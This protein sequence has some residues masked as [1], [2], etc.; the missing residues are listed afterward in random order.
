MLHVVSSACLSCMLCTLLQ[1]AVSDLEAQVANLPTGALSTRAAAALKDLLN[2]GHRFTALYQ[3]A[4]AV[5]G[6]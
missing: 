2:T 1:G 4:Q 6:R 3:K 5:Q